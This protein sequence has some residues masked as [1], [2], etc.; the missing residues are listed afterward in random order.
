MLIKYW[1]NISMDRFYKADKAFGDYIK[2]R[3]IID[4][5][6]ICPTCKRRVDAIYAECGHF[7]PRKHNPVRYDERNAHAQCKSCNSFHDG[8]DVEYKVFMIAK[9]GMDIV[10]EL[11]R[12]SK[13][14]IKVDKLFLK[15]IED[16]YK[17]K[18]K[19]I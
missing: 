10:N 3:D 11:Y 16:M 14:Y 12:K 17:E 2:K 4:G 1:K 5:Y 13:E 15:E 9:Y 6:F 7:I 18:I 8:R 19:I